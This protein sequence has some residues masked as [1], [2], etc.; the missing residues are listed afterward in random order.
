MFLDSPT[1]AGTIVVLLSLM[2][3]TVGRVGAQSLSPLVSGW[4]QFFRVESQSVSR[5]GRSV[6][7][8]TV[9]STA[10]WSSRR[11]QLLV[12]ALDGNGQVV[13]QRVAWLGV[14]LTAGTHAFFDVPMPA[15]ASYRVSVF[16]FD[17]ARGAAGN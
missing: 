3:V 11:I 1:R 4:E 8:G 14:D 10:P 17:S 6:V 5:E 12:E 9:W 16:A 7:S 13:N 15:A 2:L